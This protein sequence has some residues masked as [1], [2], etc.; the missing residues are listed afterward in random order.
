MQ[1]SKI[2]IKELGVT[3]T[4][5]HTGYTLFSREGENIVAYQQVDGRHHVIP[6]ERAAATLDD[7]R[8]VVDLIVTALGDSNPR[9]GALVSKALW[10]DWQD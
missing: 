7:T 2:E 9:A 6:R 1:T 3:V 5:E 4:K 10:Q 8:A